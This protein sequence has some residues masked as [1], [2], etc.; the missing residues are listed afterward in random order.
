MCHFNEN[1]AIIEKQEIMNTESNVEENVLHK[2]KF[3]TFCER[4]GWEFVKRT[5]GTNGVMILP[6]TIDNCFVVVEEWREPIQKNLINFPAGVIEDGEGFAEAAERE[7]LEETGYEMGGR[8]EFYQIATSAGITNEK[9]FVFPAYDCI[10]VSYGGGMFDEGEQIKVHKVPFNNL[11]QW[12]KIKES[13][14]CLI[15]ASLWMFAF[16]L[17]TAETLHKKRLLENDSDKL[18]EVIASFYDNLIYTTKEDENEE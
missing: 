7:L 6:L 2:G 10:K 4:N 18:K 14:G 11:F 8:D 1:R 3:L 9:L 16:G 15:G 5:K 12:L 17:F 13:N